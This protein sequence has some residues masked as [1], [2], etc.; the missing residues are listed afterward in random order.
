MRKNYL[1]LNGP[2]Y[3]AAMAVYDLTA[4]KCLQC[5]NRIQSPSVKYLLMEN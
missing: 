2:C 1:V 5:W 3:F 4:A